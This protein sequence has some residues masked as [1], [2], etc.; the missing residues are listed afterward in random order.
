MSSVTL[1]SWVPTTDSSSSCSAPGLPDYLRPGLRRRLRPR[2]QPG[3]AHRRRG[4]RGEARHH[5]TPGRGRRR[6]PA[7]VRRIRLHVGVPNLPQ[8]RRRPYPADLR[9][10]LRN[11]EGDHRPFHGP[12]TPDRTAHAVPPASRRQ[13]VAHYRPMRHPDAVPADRT[14]KMA[15]PT[16]SPPPRWQGSGHDVSCGRPCRP[17]PPAV[18]LRVGTGQIGQ[19]ARADTA[20]DPSDRGSALRAAFPKSR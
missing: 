11:H 1:S 2:T 20:E 7:D 6:L 13:S 17:R 12:V 16:C 19:T 18:C 4:R 15:G 5:R 10:Y 9:R 14:T 3:H 8:I